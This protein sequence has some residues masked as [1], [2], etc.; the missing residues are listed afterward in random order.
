[1]G[2]RQSCS[3]LTMTSMCQA[4][5]GLLHAYGIHWEAFRNGE[6]F[7][8]KLEKQRPDCLVL[9]LNQA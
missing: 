3:S 4:L 8:A 5:G 7:L 6:E 9:D 2:T 1:M